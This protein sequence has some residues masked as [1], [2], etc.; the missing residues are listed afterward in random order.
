M[1]R[2]VTDY[3]YIIHYIA[4]EISIHEFLLFIIYYSML[5]VVTPD[6]LAVAREYCV[7][8]YVVAVAV[9]LYMCGVCVCVINC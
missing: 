5:F 8:V 7:H 4:C 3:I 1:V 2:A 9:L 6:L